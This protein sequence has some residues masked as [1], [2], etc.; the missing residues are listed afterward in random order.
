MFAH[1]WA[2]RA[3]GVGLCRRFALIKGGSAQFGAGFARESLGLAF[4]GKTPRRRRNG[5]CRRWRRARNDIGVEID[6]GLL[7]ELAANLVAQDARR[8]FGDL[9][10]AQIAQLEGPEG[11]AD[12]PIDAEAD[13]LK[14]ALDLAVL[15]LAQ[16]HGNPD[17][18]AL[19]T[20]QLGLDAGIIDAVDAHAGAQRIEHGLLDLAMRTHPVAPQPTGSGQ[21][22]H[23]RQA[24]VI[25]EQQ[26]AFGV[27][28]EPPDGD[29]ARHI[30]RQALKYRR[31]S[32]GVFSGGDKPARLVEKEQPR[33][34]GRAHPLAVDAHIVADRHVKRGTLEHRA[35]DADAPG[36]DPAFRVAARAKPSPRHGLGD[37]LAVAD[38]FG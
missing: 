22:E 10:L 8:H 26:Q 24:A 2:I 7:G 5:A 19:R 18:R 32:F 35:I 1:F 9:A 31:A 21:F 37:A 17:V 20:I 33:A 6:I 14:H 11:N 25:G 28:I 15:A 12:Q 34:F 16:A 13:M 36:D 4:C 30:R 27:Y 29:D 38:V 3:L 23:P